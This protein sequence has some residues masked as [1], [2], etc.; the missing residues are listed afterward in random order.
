MKYWSIVH[1]WPIS[2]VLIIKQLNHSEIAGHIQWNLSNADTIGAI[3]VSRVRGVPTSE[4]SGIFLV[5]V[6]MLTRAIEYSG[7][8]F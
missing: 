4:A 8:A 5:G 6:V 3:L 2:T 7:G 1:S